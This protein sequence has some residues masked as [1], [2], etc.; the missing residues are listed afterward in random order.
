SVPFTL[1]AAPALASLE[2]ALNYKTVAI[3]E[4]FGQFLYYG[5]ALVLAVAGAGVWAPTAAYFSWQVWLLAST[6]VAARYR[7]SFVWRGRLV[8]EML[9]YGS[10]YSVSTWLW[11]L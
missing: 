7:P 9:G 11:Q 8:R 1:L 3:I 4:M 5:I 6:Y 2:R 10:S